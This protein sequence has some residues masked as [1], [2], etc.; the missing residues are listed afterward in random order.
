M[1]WFITHTV[2][3]AD[4]SCIQKHLQKVAWIFDIT[5]ECE[6]CWMKPQGGGC[7]RLITEEQDVEWVDS[8]SPH[9]WHHLLPARQTF[10]I[11][12]LPI[13]TLPKL[14]KKRKGEAMEGR[15]QRKSSLPL[16]LKTSATLW[17]AIIWRSKEFLKWTHSHAHV[18]VVQLCL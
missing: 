15:K 11:C 5:P 16:H 7:Y 9:H 10:I 8:S 4:G 1:H 12:P 14:V 6:C 18:S 17:V 13:Y 2:N 3:A